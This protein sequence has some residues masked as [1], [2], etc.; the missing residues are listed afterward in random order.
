MVGV[1]PAN[2]INPQGKHHQPTSRDNNEYGMPLNMA[3][4]VLETAYT[5]EVR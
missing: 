5:R 3:L 1:F 4:F 2:L